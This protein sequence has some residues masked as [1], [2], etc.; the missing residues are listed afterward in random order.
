MKGFNL[1]FLEELKAKN[2]I[3]EV[4]N[5][6]VPLTRRGNSFWGKCPFHHEK[7]ASFCVNGTD[8]FYYCFGC[9]K[10]GDVISFVREM[11]SLD[12]TD[13]VRYL[14][15]RAKIPVPDFSVDDTVVKEQKRK[16]ET[17][18]AVLK[19]TARFYAANLR[20]GSCPAHEEYVKKRRLSRATLDKF[21]IGASKDYDGLVRFLREKGYSYENMADA[22][23]VGKNEKRG[24][25]SYYDALAG[26]LIIPVIDGFG[27]VVAF[28]G[29]IIT[30]RKDV[31]KYVNTRET[32]V[33]T[34]GKTLFNLNNLKK[35]KAEHGLTEVIVVEGHMDVVSLVQGGVENVVASMGTALTKDQARII[36]RYADKVLISYDG[37]FAGQKA[38]VRGLEI[39]RDEGLD[40]KVV[41]LPDGMDPDDVI[42]NYGK[43]GYEKLLTEAMPLPDFKLNILKKTFDV[44]TADG[45][46]KFVANALR[47]VKESDSAAE[48]EDLLKGV[49]DY[50]GI[51]L[52]ALKR[53]LERT[54]GSVKEQPAPVSETPVAGEKTTVAARYVLY[55]LLFGKPFAAYEDI[56]DAEFL[57]PEHKLIAEYIAESKKEGSV[58]RFS[59]LYT[60]TEEES[61][62]E[63]DLIAGLSVEDARFDAETYYLD[64]LKTLKIYSF[65]KKLEA[66]NSRYKTE[67]D[68]EEKS[69]IIAEIN[70]VIV[71]RKELN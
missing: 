63:L 60:I 21:G 28:C 46:R 7:T 2:D 17:L 38:S 41:A 27:N 25:I 32:S 19:D 54:D 12:F 34:K 42:K 51:T 71:A 22:G 29:R 59:D 6:Y 57:S 43:E 69:R 9:H 45:K 24:K 23:V 36:K 67:T 66:L 1:K 40:V 39:L 4:I 18:Y 8:Q 68:A 55:A 26:R 50:S 44:N 30:D 5:G 53:D 31:G 35:Y 58:L 70:R 61:H 13:A 3:V 47:V 64:C 52:E 11:E 15:D 37:D 16:R 56:A 20:S 62:A 14:A 65:D 48:Q 49:R 33:F 10:S